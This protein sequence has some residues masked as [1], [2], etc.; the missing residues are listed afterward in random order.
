MILLLGTYSHVVEDS[1]PEPEEIADKL[2]LPE[3]IE[4]LQYL[5]SICVN[6]NH[7]DWPQ[8]MKQL[9]EMLPE[10]DLDRINW[11]TEEKRQNE[12]NG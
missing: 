11:D 6:S 8:V 12:K 1:W 2:K 5:T 9:R 3:T 7:D 4:T 10:T